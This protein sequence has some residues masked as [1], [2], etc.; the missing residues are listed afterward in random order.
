[1]EELN[2][3]I[4]TI[5]RRNARVEADKSWETSFTRRGSIVALTYL[6]VVVY[7][8]VIGNDRPFINAVVPPV[9]FLLSTLVMHRI[10]HIWQRKVY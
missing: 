4:E 10:K 5:E 2:R 3:R 6:V 1:M 7:L 8:I 9:G